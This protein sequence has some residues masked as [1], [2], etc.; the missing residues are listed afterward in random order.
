MSLDLNDQSVREREDR[1]WT[2]AL[3]T[4]VRT[5]EASDALLDAAFRT[6]A[7]LEEGRQGSGRRGSNPHNQLG[8]SFA[9]L[10]STCGGGPKLGLSCGLKHVFVTVADRCLP[11]LRARSR[12]TGLG[13]RAELDIDLEPERC[14]NSLQGRERGPNSACLEAPDCGLAGPHPAGELTLAGPAASLASRIRSPTSAARRA[15]A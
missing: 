9:G 2:F 6:L 8:R 12:M 1:R 7:F 5:P 3:L 10:L 14:G 13:S 11:V 4:A 15:S